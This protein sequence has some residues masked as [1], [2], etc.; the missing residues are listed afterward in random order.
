MDKLDDNYRRF[1]EAYRSGDF[2]FTGKLVYEIM[3]NLPG[4]GNLAK[5]EWQYKFADLMQFLSRTRFEFDEEET[6]YDMLAS[7]AIKVKENP[8][9]DWKGI[10]N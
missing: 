4:L 9:R 8:Y 5:E 6:F 10:L 1:D 2:Y 3:S 7:I